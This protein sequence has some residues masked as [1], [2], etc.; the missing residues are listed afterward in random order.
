MT[1]SETSSTTTQPTVPQPTA[2]TQPLAALSYDATVPRNLVHR[3]SVAEVFVTDSAE[4]APHTY[5]VAAQ[6]P[7]GH[8]IGENA[9]IY[10]YT[11]LIEVVRQAG[12]LA[13]HRYLGV[14]LG[15]VFIFRHLHLST[16]DVERLRIGTDPAQVLVRMKVE[17]RRNKAGRLQG[18][19][20]TGDVSLDGGVVLLGEG[21]LLVLSPQAYQKLRAKRRT[22]GPDARLPRFTPAAPTTVGRREPRNIFITEP[23]FTGR[24][25]ASCVLVTDPSHPHM[26][27]HPLDHVPGHLQMEAARQLAIASVSRLH[28]LSAETLTIGGITTDFNDYAE[29]DHVTELRASADG[30]QRHDTLSTLAVP[31]TIE[32]AQGSTVTT[33]IRVEVVQWGI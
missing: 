28:G 15:T 4:T 8:L 24:S 18:F 31:V 16:V 13:A 20:F 19:T 29:L 26:F 11:L 27:D 22:A 17:P 9:P 5:A 23:V 33:T 30:L 14:E 32:V 1:V 6:L 21:T 10:D 25:E 7:R 12:V 2:T 3:T